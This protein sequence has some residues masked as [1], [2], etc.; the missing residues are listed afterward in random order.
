[1]KTAELASTP[2]SVA[3]YVWGAVVEETSADLRSKRAALSTGAHISFF[4]P[5]ILLTTGR[6]NHHLSSTLDEEVKACLIA[7]LA[8]TERF[9]ECSKTPAEGV[10]PTHR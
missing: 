10:S 4:F 6:R 1:M 3:R 2:L 9:S 7:G 5:F 8:T